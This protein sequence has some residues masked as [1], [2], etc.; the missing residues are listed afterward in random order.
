LGKSFT[1]FRV[2]KQ[3]SPPIHAADDLAN[4]FYMGDYDTVTG[5]VQHATSGF[6]GGFQV[7]V[8]ENDE[9]LLPNS[10]VQANDFD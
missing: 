6:V 4:P 8:G 10:R 2:T 3:S 5:D 1:N 7:V 9:N